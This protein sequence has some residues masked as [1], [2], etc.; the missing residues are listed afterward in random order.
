MTRWLASTWSPL[1]FAIALLAPMPG[2]AEQLTVPGAHDAYNSVPFVSQS[3]RY[4]LLYGAALFPGPRLIT[5][6]AFSPQ[7][8]GVVSGNIQVRLAHT[9]VAIDEQTTALD[10]NVP[11]GIAVVFDAP[12]FSQSVAG[13][14]ESFSLGF[15]LDTPFLYD[16]AFGNLVVDMLVSETPN[17]FFVSSAA[18]TSSDLGARA[19]NSSALGD[20]ADTRSTRVRFTLPESGGV[21]SVLTVTLSLGILRAARPDRNTPAARCPSMPSASV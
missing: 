2:A 21:A 9:P 20:A 16:P 6:L 3:G 19:L 7:S 18:F 17:S 5:A 14:S 8:D 15:P 12:N 4:Q 13:G 10:D 11:N 1:R